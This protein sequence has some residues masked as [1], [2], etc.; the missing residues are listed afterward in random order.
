MPS[1]LGDSALGVSMSKR[2]I[3]FCVVM[4][5]FSIAAIREQ[6]WP[7][8]VEVAPTTAADF[9]APVS[10][11]VAEVPKETGPSKADL[12]LASQI[13]FELAVDEFTQ[14]VSCKVTEHDKLIIEVA[15]SWHYEPQPMRLQAA[16]HFAKIWKR[17]DRTNIGLFSIVDISGNEVGGLGI[18]GVWVSD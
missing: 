9:V 3:A 8:P 6:I 7:T 10:K 14:V 15:Q 18:T 4:G 13:K 1:V 12:R 5:W 2:W 16:Q 11:P 17:I